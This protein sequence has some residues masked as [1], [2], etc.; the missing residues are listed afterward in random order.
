MKMPWRVTRQRLKVGSK[1]HG[2]D[3]QPELYFHKL[4]APH[5]EDEPAVSVPS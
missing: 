5:R 2:R 3:A 4:K 1:A